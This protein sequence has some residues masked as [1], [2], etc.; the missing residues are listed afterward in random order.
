[1]NSTTTKTYILPSHELDIAQA[2]KGSLNGGVEA[3]YQWVHICDVMANTLWL[4]GE[5]KDAFLTACDF[6]MVIGHYDW[7]SELCY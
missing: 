6:D 5:A 2:L 3:I 7:R 4:A 1:M